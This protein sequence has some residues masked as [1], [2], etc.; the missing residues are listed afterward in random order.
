MENLKEGD[1]VFSTEHQCN[2]TVQKIISKEAVECVW[3]DSDDKPH[4]EIINKDKLAT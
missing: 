3:F 1:V 2:V 4:K